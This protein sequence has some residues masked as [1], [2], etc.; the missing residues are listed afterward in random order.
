MRPSAETSPDALTLRQRV[1][2]LASQAIN[3]VVF[4]GDPGEPL[5]VRAWRE[6]RDPA[7]SRRRQCIDR[8]LGEN[9]CMNAYLA[10]ALREMHRAASTQQTEQGSSTP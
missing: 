7:W 3:A 10:H 8:R 9:H 2:L 6:R 4:A 1:W 5:S